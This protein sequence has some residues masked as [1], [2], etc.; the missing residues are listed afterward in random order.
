MVLNGCNADYESQFVNV[1]VSDVSFG[2]GICP[3]TT[4][5][6]YFSFDSMLVSI[7]KL[8]VVGSRIEGEGINLSTEPTG[9]LGTYMLRVPGQYSIVRYLNIPKGSYYLLGW[10]VFLGLSDA[11]VPSVKI[12]GKYTNLNGTTLPVIFTSTKRFSVLQMITN[13]FAHNSY[14]TILGGRRYAA[15]FSLHP[16]AAFALV[17]RTQFENAQYVTNE[18]VNCM[19]ISKE[20]NEQLFSQIMSNLESNMVLQL[21]EI[22]SE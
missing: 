3:T 17:P 9:E 4:S 22:L 1:M 15:S 8:Q 5:L 20:S 16:L 10:E 21:S 6:S 2:V 19:L 14:Y 7:S 12:W 18:G 11:N 13:G